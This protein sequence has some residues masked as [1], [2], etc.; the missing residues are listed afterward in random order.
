M[1]KQKRSEVVKR[2][3]RYLQTMQTIH[4]CRRWKRRKEESLKRKGFMGRESKGDNGRVTT[5][6][7][8]LVFV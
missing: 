8:L 5:I 3:I 6:K 4:S 2:L 1:L 7:G